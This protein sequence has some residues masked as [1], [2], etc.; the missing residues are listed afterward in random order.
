[1]KPSSRQQK[2]Q[3][4]RCHHRPPHATGLSGPPGRTV[5]PSQAAQQ[6]APTWPAPS[7][8]PSPPPNQ[9]PHDV[10]RRPTRCDPTRGRPIPPLRA[11]A[12]PPPAS[13]HPTAP[14]PPLLQ[15]RTRQFNTENQQPTAGER[16]KEQKTYPAHSGTPTTT[17]ARRLGLGETCPRQPATTTHRRDEGVRPPPPPVPLTLV[18]STVHSSPSPTC[19]CALR[20]CGGCV[21]AAPPR[22]GCRCKTWAG[23]WEG[24]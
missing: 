21:R 4:L 24:G 13:L 17:A 3:P 10:T 15:R 23:W 12:H 7:P 20:W 16:A 9:G 18:K 5:Q 22:T 11:P 19:A 2:A 6:A 8:P 1:M 14:S